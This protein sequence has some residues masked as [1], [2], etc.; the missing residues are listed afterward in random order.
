MDFVWKTHFVKLEKFQQ[1]NITSQVKQ[2][3]WETF[4]TVIL[5]MMSQFEIFKTI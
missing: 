3:T 1:Q 2:S 5:S 4:K